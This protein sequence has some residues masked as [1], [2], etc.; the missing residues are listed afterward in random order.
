MDQEIMNDADK[1]NALID[2]QGKIQEK[3]DQLDAWDLDSKLEL[4]ME[5]LRTPEGDTPIKR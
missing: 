5:A 3:I 2:K 1:M 4:A